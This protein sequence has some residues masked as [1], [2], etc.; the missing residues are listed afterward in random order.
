M[1]TE[2]ASFFDT[3]VTTYKT[4]WAYNPEDSTEIFTALKASNFIKYFALIKYYK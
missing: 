4:A 3:L 1:K 2:V